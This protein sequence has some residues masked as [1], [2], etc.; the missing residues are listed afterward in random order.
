MFIRNPLEQDGEVLPMGTGVDILSTNNPDNID[1]EKESIMYEKYDPLLHGGSRKRTDKILSVDFMRKYI[2]FVKIMKPTLTEEASEIIAD[3]Y[4][5]L[6]S[7]DMLE[8]HV[9]RVSI[10]FLVKCLVH[11]QHTY[12]FPKFNAKLENK[13]QI[14]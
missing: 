3:E 7:E 11:Q 4:S 1:G 5:K 9:A 13:I 10:Y 12:L 8:N 6:R 2:H 14:I